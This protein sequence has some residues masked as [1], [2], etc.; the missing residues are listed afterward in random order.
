M[1]EN[2]KILD[3]GTIVREDY[4]FSQVKG[5][6]VQILPFQRKVWKIYLLTLVT[7]GIYGIIIGFSMAKET[8]IAC[9][10]DGKHTRGFWAVIGLTLIT[11]GIYAIIWYVGWLNRESD[12]L[13]SKGNDDYYSGWTWLLIFALQLIPVPVLPL[14][15]GIYS[16]TK[17]VQQHNAVNATYNELNNFVQKI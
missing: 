16:L 8:N 3:D 9:A 12:F 10:G 2:Y 7:F 6:G 15:L 13:K 5:E 1:S 4:F 17:I 14:L 11:F